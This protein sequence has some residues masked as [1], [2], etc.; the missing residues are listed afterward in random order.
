[1]FIIYG[2]G[3]AIA[4]LTGGVIAAFLTAA[5]YERVAARQQAY[6]EEIAQGRD[7]YAALAML[8]HVMPASSTDDEAPAA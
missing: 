5:H 8:R 6:E 7:V 1:V 3:L 2:T 4:L